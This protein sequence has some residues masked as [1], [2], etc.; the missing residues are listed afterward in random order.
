MLRAI[1]KMVAIFLLAGAGVHFWYG[2][3]EKQLLVVEEHKEQPAANN[4]DKPTVPAKTEVPET[5][6]RKVNDAVNYQII[7]SRNIFQAVIE[8]QEK[9]PEK[10]VKK[11]VPTS[12][13]LTLLGTVAGDEHTARAIIIDNKAKKQDIFQ[14]GDAIQGAFI[15]T[16]ERGKVTLDVNGRPE[17]LTIKKREGG[18]PGAPQMS[19]RDVPSVHQTAS[20]P[21]K[22]RLRRNRR[23]SRRVNRRV[24][25][26]PAAAEAE[27]IAEI[28]DEPVN[29]PD[30]QVD[31]PEDETFE[32]TF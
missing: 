21:R 2:R 19:D 5:L 3:V 26:V 27:A 6:N 13:D 7:A 11:V 4:I 25:K 18:G 22:P 14:I 8:V 1:V 15:E 31:V 29:D 10:V 28:I 16:I 20:A 17:T 12:L 23:I 32:P 9:V 24:A 30:E